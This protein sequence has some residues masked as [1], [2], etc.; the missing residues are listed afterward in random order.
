MRYDN[1]I[2]KQLFFSKHPDDL[3]YFEFEDNDNRPTLAIYDPAANDGSWADQYMDPDALRYVDPDG[4]VYVKAL[5]HGMHQYVL[6]ACYVNASE[7]ESILRSFAESKVPAPDKNW[8]ERSS[9]MSRI[10]LG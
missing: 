4:R 1:K 6:H 10:H 7:G 3:W 8:V 2:H 9:V 5:I